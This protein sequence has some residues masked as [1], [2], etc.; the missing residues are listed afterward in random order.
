[1][2][3]TKTFLG[4]IVSAKYSRLIGVSAAA[5]LFVISALV[6]APVCKTQDDTFAAPTPSTTTLA[7]TTPSVSL[8]LALDD[9]A[10]TFAVSDPASFSV[11]TNNYTGYALS[12][13]AKEDNANNS[14]LINGNYAL[15]SISSAAVDGTG[16][17]VGDWGYKPSKLNSADNTDFLPSP[18]YAGSVLNATTTANST[19]DNY[20]LAIAAKADYTTITGTY[21]NTFVLTAVPNPVNYT[22]TYDKNTTDNVTNMPAAQVGTLSDQDI[23]ISSTVPSRAGYNFDGWCDGDVTTTSGT[24]SCSGIEYNPGA[25]YAASMQTANTSN[26]KAIWNVPGTARAILGSNGNLN[27]VYDNNTY[28]V[29]ET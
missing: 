29:G 26:L 6:L 14:K 16:F 3:E 1:M 7:M 12:I 10:G 2:R 17:S 28:T 15:N 8:S 9:A 24:Q 5:V 21:S 11:T 18:T 25:V 22:I 27:F 23:I 4:S 13:R 19:A 20:S